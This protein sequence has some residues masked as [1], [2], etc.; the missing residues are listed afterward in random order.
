MTRWLA[1]LL[2]TSALGC[3]PEIRCEEAQDK[4]CPSG[5][6]EVVDPFIDDADC[7]EFYDGPC[8]D[9]WEEYVACVADGETTCYDHEAEEY[10]SMSD[11]EYDAFAD[12]VERYPR[13]HLDT[14][15]AGTDFSNRFAPLP[16]SY[17]ERLAGLGDRVVL[18][19]DFPNIPYP[20]AHQLEAL[21]RL[22]LGDDWLRDIC[23]HNGVRLFQTPPDTPTHGTKGS[24]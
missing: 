4:D 10:T 9:E 16:P 19:S 1:V 23:W 18:G 21:A 2:V 12:L 22:G 20:Y 24:E 13:V 7:E 5:Q 11:C 3:G 15:M 6:Q 17:V 14:T 8:S